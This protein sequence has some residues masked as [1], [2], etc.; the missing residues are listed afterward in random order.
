VVD[1]VSSTQVKVE[2]GVPQGTVLG[3]MLFL[4]HINDLPDCVSSRVR[5]FADDCLL[6]RPIYETSDQHALQKD[7]DLLAVWCDSWCMSFNAAKC[8]VKRISRKKT[9]LQ[10]IYTIKGQALQEVNKARYLG[11]VIS[12]DVQWSTHVS[13]ITKKANSTLGFLRRNLKN[14]PPKLKEIAYF[15]LVRSVVEYSATVWDPHLCKDR[16]ALEMIQR[17]AARNVKNDHRQTSSNSD[18][19]RSWLGITGRP[20]M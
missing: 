16:D 14:A 19:E 13:T 9:I 10:K 3:L 11:V 5:W 15:S 1:G 8:E 12:N 18:V 7:L 2:S 17:R 20:Q 6:Y 4:L